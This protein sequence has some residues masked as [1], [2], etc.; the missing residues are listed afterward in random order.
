M[1]PQKSRK[2]AK[3]RIT[4]ESRKGDF[5]L[6]EN[7]IPE[8][9]WFNG[10]VQYTLLSDKI[11]KTDQRTPINKIGGS[12]TDGKSLI[13]PMKVFRGKQPYDPDNKTLVTPHTAGN[14]DTGYWKAKGRQ[15][16]EAADPEFIADI[17][18][19]QKF[20]SLDYSSWDAATLADFKKQNAF[21]GMRP[22]VQEAY[23]ALRPWG[24]FLDG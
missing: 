3:G 17:R 11:E 12:P 1:H 4:Y 5:T 2:D 22:E 21:A 6:A 16:S 8:Y 7:V 18:K 13:W 14:D 15:A 23:G 24:E 10:N 9:A 19:G 20:G